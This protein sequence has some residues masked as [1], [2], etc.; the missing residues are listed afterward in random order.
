MMA[1]Q[2][3]L[4]KRGGIVCKSQHGFQMFYM[5]ENLLPIKNYKKFKVKMKKHLPFRL[6][7]SIMV[8]LRFKLSGI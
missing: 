2:L 4:V 5:G 3:Y 6:K 7:C 8:R 1:V